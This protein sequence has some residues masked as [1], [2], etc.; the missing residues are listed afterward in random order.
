MKK[1]KLP[2]WLYT[3][4]GVM[5]R[6]SQES[7][8][9]RRI[10]SLFLTYFDGCYGVDAEPNTANTFAMG[11]CKIEYKDNENKLVVHLRRPGLLIGK[12][13]RTIDALSKRLDCKIGIVEVN[14]RG[15]TVSI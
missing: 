12:G 14:L 1:V 10:K 13:G 5:P 11:V 6:F 15:I 9:S 2:K 4:F 8:N 3:I 7:E